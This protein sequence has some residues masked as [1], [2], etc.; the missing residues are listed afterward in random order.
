M[1]AAAEADD[2]ESPGVAVAD[3]WIIDAL[4]ICPC[5]YFPLVD[6]GA[7]VGLAGAAR[8]GAV[9]CGRIGV[10]AFVIPKREGAVDCGLTGVLE[11]CAAAL[12]LDMP[13]L[14]VIIALAVL[15]AIPALSVIS[16]GG[17]VEPIGIKL[18]VEL[19]R[20]KP[21]V[22]VVRP[23]E[24]GLFAPLAGLL[25]EELVGGTAVLADEIPNEGKYPS[26]EVGALRLCLLVGVTA[27]CPCP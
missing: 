27:P 18:L 24:H 16:I 5:A 13:P 26:G 20:A 7:G 19:P 21:A 6:P 15:P 10:P 2:E 8:D 22:G 25:R 17:N 9:D 12:A 11:E 4:L 3:R 14:V 1:A 23:L